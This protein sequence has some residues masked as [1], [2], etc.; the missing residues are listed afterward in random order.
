MNISIFINK[1]EICPVEQRR[2]SNAEC[3]AVLKGQLAFGLQALVWATVWWN[4]SCNIKRLKHRCFWESYRHILQCNVINLMCEDSL[5]HADT[6]IHT[7][8]SWRCVNKQSEWQQGCITW[9]CVLMRFSTFTDTCGTLRV[10]LVENWNNLS[11]F[12]FFS[13]SLLVA[14]PQTTFEVCEHKK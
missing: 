7:P 3:F 8:E 10:P 13:L 2:L 4:N 6:H 1:C 5:T 9:T 11:K 12:F 14:E